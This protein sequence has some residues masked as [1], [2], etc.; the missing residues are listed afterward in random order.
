MTPADDDERDG[1]EDD[2]PDTPLDEPPPEPIRD[3]PA[4]PGPQGP[5]VVRSTSETDLIVR[6]CGRSK[7]TQR[8]WRVSGESNRTQ[9]TP[10]LRIHESRAAA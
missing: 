8:Q 4:E 2:I 5:Y 6:A 9:G 3:P 1:D 7:L 10:W